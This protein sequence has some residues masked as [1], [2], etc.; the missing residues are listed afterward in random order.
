MKIKLALALVSVNIMNHFTEN[1]EKKDTLYKTLF[2]YILIVCL[3]LA[4]ATHI[5]DLNCIKVLMSLSLCILQN[6]D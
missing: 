2:M 4:A 6:S 3:C 1:V 5:C